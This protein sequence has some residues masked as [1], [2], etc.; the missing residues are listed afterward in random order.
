MIQTEVSVIPLPDEEDRSELEIPE[1]EEQPEKRTSV[2]VCRFE[3]KVLTLY[4][5]KLFIV[6]ACGHFLTSLGFFRFI[7]IS[8]THPFIL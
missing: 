4:K 6:I 8:L 2:E 5:V 1:T 7:Q 3:P